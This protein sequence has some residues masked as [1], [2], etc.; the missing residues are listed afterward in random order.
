M[1]IYRGC[2]SSRKQQLQKKQEKYQTAEG[3]P[4]LERNHDQINPRLDRQ[5]NTVDSD[6]DERACRR[7]CGSWRLEVELRREAR[8]SRRVARSDVPAVRLAGG[9]ARR[10]GGAGNRGVDDQDVRGQV[11]HSELVR[12]GPARCAPAEQDRGAA[13]GGTRG[14]RGSRAGVGR[15]GGGAA[16]AEA[17]TRKCSR[18]NRNGERKASKSLR[19]PC[20]CF[21][22]FAPCRRA[23]TTSVPRGMGQLSLAF[24][25][26][27]ML[28]PDRPR[29]QHFEAPT[30]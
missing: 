9:E 19:R 8:A 11:S 20:P 2:R 17:E 3:H 26:V 30:G 27:S 18:A 15:G 13:H 25:E 21:N 28:S 23:C 10:V 4:A 29:S 22:V 16:T 5:F 12:G 1:N 24:L 14:A 7:S 6:R